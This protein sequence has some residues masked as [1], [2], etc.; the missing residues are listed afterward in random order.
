MCRTGKRA[1]AKAVFALALTGNASFG[2]ADSYW[3]YAFSG[4]WTVG[5]N[6]VNGVPGAGANVYI[7]HTDS[8]IRTVTYNYT[9][10]SIQFNGMHVDH[11]GFGSTTFAQSAS[12]TTFNA[13]AAHDDGRTIIL[14]FALRGHAELTERIEQ[15]TEVT[16]ELGTL[17][18]F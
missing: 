7:E 2:L 13:V 18:R 10:G 4:N 17:D 5:S 1:I 16:H 11:L 8:N 15:G 3:S 14:P 12:N 9:G 6:W